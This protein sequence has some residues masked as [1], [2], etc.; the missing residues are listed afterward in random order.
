MSKDRI[1]TRQELIDLVWGNNVIISDR[2]ID[3]HIRNIRIKIGKEHGDMIKTISGKGYG[4]IESHEPNFF[5]IFSRGMMK[6]ITFSMQ[7]LC[8]LSNSAKFF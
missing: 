4:I 3:V 6:A 2:S 1:F 7:D 8:H 5:F